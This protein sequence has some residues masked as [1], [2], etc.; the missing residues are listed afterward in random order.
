MMRKAEQ[1]AKTLNKNHVPADNFKDVAE[2]KAT[3][4]GVGLYWYDADPAGQR[5]PR[6]EVWQIRGGQWVRKLGEIVRSY[7]GIWR[8]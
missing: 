1:I 6:V 8:T 4:I 5:L 3:E 7:K 2:L